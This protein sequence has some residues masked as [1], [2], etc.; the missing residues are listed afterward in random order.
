[1]KLFSHHKRIETTTLLYILLALMFLT[2]SLL[3]DD[4]FSRYNITSMLTNIAYNGIIA[5]TMTLLLISGAIDISVGGI[6]GCVT[7]LMAFL[8]DSY[9]S[10]PVWMILL[11]GLC[12]GALIGLVNGYL[13]KRFRLDPLI[14][15]LGVM[16]I[17]RGL[18]YVLTKGISILMMEP[19]TAFVGL[20]KVLGIPVAFFIMLFSFGLL[21]IVLKRSKFGRKIFVIGVNERAAHTAGIDAAQIRLIL[22]I[23]SGVA[24]AISSIML[25]GQ[26]AVGM[27]QH[28]VGAEF[29]AITAALLGGTA[30]T[31]G[32][33]SIGGTLAGVLI[34][35]VLFTGLTIVGVKAVQINLFRGLL[36]ILVVA[37]YERREEGR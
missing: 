18:A 36:L 8:Y 9:P 14:V 29:E 33:G 10:F 16:A 4:F 17:T 24:A 35:G 15:T 28:G 32:K 5:G 6:I 12:V 13:V 37:L 22:F 21:H 23:I 11:I 26:S 1:M 19:V 34:L 27:P 3:S 31:G 7:S 30:F 25:I 2:F 20:G